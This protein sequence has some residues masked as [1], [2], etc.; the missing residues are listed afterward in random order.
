MSKEEIERTLEAMIL[1]PR[2]PV[3]T[4]A[5]CPT[6]EWYAVSPDDQASIP[7]GQIARTGDLF[8]AIREMIDA[9]GETATWRRWHLTCYN[10]GND[11]GRIK[12]AQTHTQ[13]LLDGIDQAHEWSDGVIRSQGGTTLSIRDKCS[14]CGL[15]RR[16]FS[17]RQ[18]GDNGS[19][20]FS[21]DGIDYSTR[22]A[23][24]L[25]C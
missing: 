23:A 6:G 10:A 16:Y 18:N 17:D 14:V 1:H 13:K 22:D 2:S 11:S 4:S 20:S 15:E 12:M 8:D 7:L 9:A 25:D 24:A 5:E 19:V 21:R 3:I